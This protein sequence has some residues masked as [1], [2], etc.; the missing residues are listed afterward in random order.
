MLVDLDPFAAAP[1][2]ASDAPPPMEAPADVVAMAPGSDTTLAPSPTRQTSGWQ[3]VPELGGEVATLVVPLDHEDPV[4]GTTEIVLSRLRATEE[5]L[6]GTLVINPGGPGGLGALWL[7]AVVADD[8]RRAFP[9]FDLVSFDPRGV[10]SSGGFECPID[11]APAQIYAEAGAA[12]L[13]QA[14]E[15]V[16]QACEQSVGPLFRRIGSHRVVQDMDHIRRFLGLE[17]LSFLGISYGGRLGASYAQTFP[18]STGAVILDA[19]I[20]PADLVQ[21]TRLQFDGVLQGQEA[22]YA[23]CA[24]GTLDCPENPRQVFEQLV[25]AA[26]A[27]GTTTE[28]SL[29]WRFIMP[30]PNAHQLLA[31]VLRSFLEDPAQVVGPVAPAMEEAMNGMDSKD[32]VA[33]LD[34]S[35]NITVNCTDNVAP[36]LSEPELDALFTEFEARSPFFAASAWAPAACAGWPHTP[37][38]VALAP[39]TGAPPLLIIA[40]EHDSLTPFVLA[41]RTRAAVSP[42]SVLLSSG[43]YGH[44]AF[45]AGAECALGAMRTFLTSGRLPADGSDCR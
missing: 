4:A 34:A 22:F 9:G 24:A 43:H 23:A 5:P 21:L 41:E 25:A 29:L 13:V 27:E 38:G 1:P 37:S 35:A 42:S 3:P 20:G 39:A 10:G 45:V 31:F 11:L 16:G 8:A 32:A 33:L 19:P 44:S 26:E 6:L 40:G 14:F 36:P 30:D 18:A 28:V 17:K 7:L 12:G 15:R 2:R